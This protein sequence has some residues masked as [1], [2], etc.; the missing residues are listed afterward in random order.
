MSDAGEDLM[1]MV[2]R[3]GFSELIRGSKGVVLRALSEATHGTPADM[4]PR[5][6]LSMKKGSLDAFM[7]RA[8]AAGFDAR[9]ESLDVTAGPESMCKVSIPVAQIEDVL[10]LCRELA[11]EGLMPDAPTKV[12][13][14]EMPTEPIQAPMTP[15]EIAQAATRPIPSVE[16]AAEAI[17]AAGGKLD[18]E[19][20][21]ID[22][23]DG[24]EPVRAVDLSVSPAPGIS[25]AM[26]VQRAAWQQDVELP[27]FAEVRFPADM[28]EKMAVVGAMH[29]VALAMP[30]DPAARVD[31]YGNALELPEGECCVLVPEDKRAA[32]EAA[33]S[34]GSMRFASEDPA[35]SDLCQ[36][37]LSRSED[38]FA[39]ARG[40]SVPCAD[41]AVGKEGFAAFEAAA[42]DVG[43]DIVADGRD[44]AGIPC[45][46]DADHV[47]VKAP[48]DQ[49]GKILAAI[50]R[51][52]ETAPKEVASKLE[53]TRGKVEE[54]FKLA[55]QKNAVDLDW[56]QKNAKEAEQRL[57]VAK[58]FAKDKNRSMER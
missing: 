34:Y 20:A 17:E 31:R 46:D 19:P 2:L 40:A 35:F 9:V 54:S 14:V 22:P 10:G 29:G 57:S 47:R 50:D 24:G 38:L 23:E 15:D 45:P 26:T 56:R 12:E 41:I 25:P 4:G 8:N 3:A 48:I 6:V 5:G 33:M 42:R 28:A 16:D 43:A 13:D 37:Q 53:E 58:S 39:E 36:K 11:A 52:A 7:E 51:A 30:D 55:R 27:G 49:E 21:M 1:E 18:A 44:S 32:F